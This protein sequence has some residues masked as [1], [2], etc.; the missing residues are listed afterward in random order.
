[1]LRLMLPNSPQ[2]YPRSE[3]GKQGTPGNFAGPSPFQALSIKDTQQKI[4]ELRKKYKRLQQI[5]E[6][7]ES[8]V[9]LKNQTIKILESRI[10]ELESTVPKDLDGKYY[11]SKDFMDLKLQLD[12]MSSFQFS[13]EMLKAEKTKLLQEIIDKDKILQE[14]QETHRTIVENNSKLQNK[15]YNLGEASNEKTDLIY[16]SLE[17]IRINIE[18]DIKEFIEMHSG[19]KIVEKD[20]VV[21]LLRKLLVSSDTGFQKIKVLT[22]Y[23]PLADSEIE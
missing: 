23:K 17:A 16:N 22:G 2:A 12:D 20:R 15:I 18:K 3:N 1:M 5:K 6:D 11:T 19:Q 7:L 4:N 9:S 8:T 10:L 14:F 13:N 21:S